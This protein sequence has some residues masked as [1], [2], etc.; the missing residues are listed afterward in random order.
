MIL[1]AFAKFLHSHPELPAHEAL[2]LWLWERMAQDPENNVDHVIQLEIGIKK[3]LVAKAGAVVGLPQEVRL[4]QEAMDRFKSE[5][6]LKND[7]NLVFKGTSSSGAKLLVS[8]YEYSMSYEQTRWSRFIHGLKAS[9][10]HG[11]T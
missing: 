7:Y 3:E 10:F 6:G 5:N 8:L 9:D 11:L 1:E 4:P 2:S